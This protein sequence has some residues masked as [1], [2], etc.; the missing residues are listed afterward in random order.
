MI[1]SG[2]GASR[3]VRAA[4]SASTV[5]MYH[6][7][8]NIAWRIVIALPACCSSS[9]YSSAVKWRSIIGSTSASSI[10]RCSSRKSRSSTARSSAVYRAS[11]AASDSVA[12]CAQPAERLA[13]GVDHAV[14]VVVVAGERVGVL[15]VGRHALGELGEEDV[16]LDVVVRAQLVAVAAE[17]APEGGG[18]LGV[19]HAE[20]CR[21]R[22]PAARWRPAS[23][24]GSRGTRTGRRPSAS[25]WSSLSVREVGEDERRERVS[26]SMSSRVGMS[27]CVMLHTLTATACKPLDVRLE[28][29]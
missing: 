29:P 10:A 24:G 4:V 20:R 13:Q 21:C 14:E 26:M 28:T 2:R 9:A 25:N 27:V 17:P 1:R 19:G 6:G 8:V 16:V 5:A 23:P 22:A 7:A 18:A 11:R 15:G 12:C 3:S